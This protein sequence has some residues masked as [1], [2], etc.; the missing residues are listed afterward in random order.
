MTE[1]FKN[2]N[3]VVKSQPTRCQSGIINFT[4]SIMSG[5]H[6]KAFKNL[7]SYL[8]GSIRPKCPEKYPYQDHGQDQRT[9]GTPD[10]TMDRNRSTLQEHQK[11]WSKT[12]I[13]IISDILICM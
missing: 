4:E 1:T 7:K 13:S 9:R 6:R 5:K 12:T 3:T 2:K 8:T 10:R 11:F